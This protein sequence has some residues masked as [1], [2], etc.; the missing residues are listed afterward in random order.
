M[1]FEKLFSEVHEKRSSKPSSKFNEMFEKTHQKKSKG[2][3]GSIQEAYRNIEEP[4]EDFARGARASIKGTPRAFS[5]LAKH[6]SE[7]LAQKGRELAESEGREIS[8]EEEKFTSAVTKGL[9]YPEQ[10]FKKIGLPTSQEALQKEMHQ[11]GI[12]EEELTPLRKGAQSGG[13]FFGNLVTAPFGAFGGPTRAGITALG[14]AGAGIAGGLGGEEGTQLLGGLTLPA[15]FKL[16]NDIRKGKFTPS[17]KEAKALY[18]WGKNKGMTEKELAPILQSSRKTSMLGGLTEKSSRGK[19]AI[20]TS[21]SALG[22]LYDKVKEK[23]SKLAPASRHQENILIEKF[24]KVA[25]E[26]NKSKIK[27]AD[28]EG[29]IKKIN[30]AIADIAANGISADE[31]ISTWQDINKAVN[32]NSF[33]T[34]KK[35]LF[36]LKEPM[37]DLFKQLAPQEA[38]EFS[39]I[40]KMWGRLQN[41]ARRIEPTDLSKFIKWGEA[42]ATVK[43]LYDFVTT[44]D[45]KVLKGL[46]IAK[47]GKHIA[48]EMLINPRLNNLTGKVLAASKSGSLQATQKAIRN[49][50]EA[51][52]EED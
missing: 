36:A 10:L 16:V 6:G 28:K 1:S 17:G 24:Q 44:G 9:G 37:M 43:G 12:N 30:E 41:V 47:G 52:K 23:S 33:K 29:A 14:S 35:S 11:A 34:G 5:G 40:N 7:Y 25:D 2:F 42:G 3:I 13:E 26:L 19:R 32:W 8:P 15:A 31:I 50:Q 21:E 27:G 46:A 39:V 48:T 22:G 4:I 38:K 45:L 18:D 51:L 20:E 49:L